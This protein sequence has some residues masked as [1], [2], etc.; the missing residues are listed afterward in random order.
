MVQGSSERSRTQSTPCRRPPG[1][2]PLDDLC[3]ARTVS[4]GRVTSSGRSGSS[5]WLGRSRDDDHHLRPARE[6]D[7][8]DGK[9][10]GTFRTPTMT[11]D[12]DDFT[13]E[14]LTI[15]NTAGTGG[16]G[17]GASR[18][19]RPRR[20]P[21]VP[22][23]RLAGHDLPES[24]PPVF[25][26]CYIA[27]HVDFIFGGATAYFERPHDPRPARRLHHRGL[28]AAC[29]ALRF[30]LRTRHHHGRAWS[31]TYLGRPWRGYAQ[32]SFIDMTMSEVVRPEGWHN[33]DKPER[34]KTVR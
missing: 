15:E 29:R 28:D 12:A 23:S 7:G 14:N 1:G 18:R 2:G 27:G 17:A 5:R 19:R 10:I 31:R 21:Q 6:H 11:I 4:R 16:A 30:R 20:L 25:R 22:V 9:P 3:Q 33:W 13:V 24:R 26:G 34:E 8:L 32:T